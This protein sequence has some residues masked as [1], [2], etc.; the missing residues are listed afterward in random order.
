MSRLKG[1]L[2][3][4]R[5]IDEGAIMK[6]LFSDERDIRD[7]W[8][9]LHFGAT[10]L[11]PMGK[12][13][14]PGFIISC[15]VPR[16]DANWEIYGYRVEQDTSD[17]SKSVWSIH[18]ALTRDGRH[19][20]GIEKLFE[21]EPGPWFHY[22]T[23]TYNPDRKEFLALKGRSQKDGFDYMAFLSGDGRTWAAHANDPVYSDGDSWGTLWS[24]RKKCYV[25]TGKAFKLVIKKFPDNAKIW[26]RNVRA[27]RAD[28]DITRVLSVRKS[29]DGRKWE[30]DAPILPS[31][32]GPIGIEAFP[33]AY[34]VEPDDQDPPELEFYRGFCFSYLDRFF[35]MMLNYAPS[36]LDDDKH[37]PQL[38][39]EWWL[40]RDGLSWQR[41]YRH[42]NA[43]P[44]SVRI[45]R[46]NPMVI[47][48]NIL[49]H[50]S[51]GHLFGMKADR[52]TF[53]GAHA[54]GEFSTRP[55]TMPQGDLYLNAAIPAPDR[56]FPMDTGYDSN[57]GSG[58]EVS[59]G[60]QSY[61]MV[62]ACDEAGNP[63]LGFE[64]E[65]CLIRRE[66]R[67]DI[68]LKWTGKSGRELAGKKICLRFFMRSA[69]V[70]AVY[71]Q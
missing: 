44:D 47:D 61:L 67:I 15:C 48:G 8:G 36:P 33:K 11:T 38:D 45:I 12:A 65:K 1:A 14:D 43:I 57:T 35:M 4:Q 53:I 59:K 19:F 34:L 52:I 41:P 22:A 58:Q 63:I 29:A 13:E 69:N 39:T 25:S 37:G 21:S 62:A 9:K 23:I 54:N 71:S 50:Y 40:S 5:P 55:F 51:D 42:I 30:P 16:D 32:T 31:G 20:E 2:F 3:D 18:R 68:P 26:D 28:H 64:R 7:S 66:D 49:F 24:S 27:S 10:P 56:M 70:Y 46:H 6:L 60:D 17:R